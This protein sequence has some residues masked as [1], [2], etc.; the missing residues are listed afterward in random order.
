LINVQKAQLDQLKR[1]EATKLVYFINQSYKLMD[2][3]NK[4]LENYFIW[5]FH[6]Y[7]ATLLFANQM[8]FTTIIL[9]F[10]EAIIFSVQLFQWLRKKEDVWELLKKSWLVLYYAILVSSGYKFFSLFSRYVIVKRLYFGLLD[11]V[12][13]ARFQIVF[14]DKRDSDSDY[15]FE[16]FKIDTIIIC[17]AFFTNYCVVS[18]TEAGTR[19]DT[20]T[21]INSN[22]SSI[23]GNE[24][25]G[26]SALMMRHTTSFTTGL[27]IFKGITFIFM[28]YHATNEPNAYKVVL[29]LVPLIYFNTLFIKI[30]KAMDEYKL[31]DLM[32]YCKPSII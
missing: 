21:I 22:L 14:I 23:E 32:E 16:A 11:L 31:R 18:R 5:L 1:Q 28:G 2:F 12:V 7:F 24:N 6:C 8:N 30:E 29:I 17:M 3:L 13:P 25:N 19:R 10:L 9:Y 15:V 20:K 27:L 4:M 26:L